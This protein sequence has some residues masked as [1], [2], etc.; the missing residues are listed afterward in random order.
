MI[1]AMI[2]WCA[3]LIGFFVGVFWASAG[4]KDE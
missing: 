2:A 4:D 1:T 3:F